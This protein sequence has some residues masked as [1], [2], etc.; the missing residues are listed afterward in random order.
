MQPHLDGKALTFWPAVL[1]LALYNNR[2]E[3]YQILKR[4]EQQANTH[5]PEKEK[6]HVSP[7]VLRHT[8]LRKLANKKGV[9]YAKKLSGHQT[10]RYIWRYVQ[11]DEQDL[12]DAL[13]EVE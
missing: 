6:I 2:R 13:D 4:M 8:T 7:H 10:D 9:H 3:A 12:A 5:L 1:R 11:P